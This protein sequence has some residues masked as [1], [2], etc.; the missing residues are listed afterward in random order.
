MCLLRI[1]SVLKCWSSTFVA[2]NCEQQLHRRNIRYQLSQQEAAKAEINFEHTWERF[3]FLLIDY[4]HFCPVSRFT[5]ALGLLSDKYSVFVVYCWFVTFLKHLWPF[6]T[7]KES[8]TVVKPGYPVMEA[9]Q[10]ILIPVRKLKLD[11]SRRNILEGHRE[12]GQTLW[13]C[14][15]DGSGLCALFRNAQS[16]SFEFTSHSFE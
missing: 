2:S 7:D 3:S 12:V 1:S 11:C 10:T 4:N 16:Q 15:R 5:S 6:K 14:D 13:T 9:V 8:H